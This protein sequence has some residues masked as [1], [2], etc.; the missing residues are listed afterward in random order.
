[1]KTHLNLFGGRRTYCG[2][3]VVRGEPPTTA[4]EAEVTCL[5]CTNLL[6]RKRKLTELGKQLAE[7]KA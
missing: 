7:G 3:E 4:Q 2:V 1:M 6:K 5:R